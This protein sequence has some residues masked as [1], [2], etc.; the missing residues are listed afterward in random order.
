MKTSE[1]PHFNKKKKYLFRNYDH[2]IT[3][4]I[5][6]K[7][8]HDNFSKD[9]SN[10]INK[11]SLK[12]RLLTKQELKDHQLEINRILKSNLTPSGTKRKKVWD[13]GWKDILKGFKKNKKIQNLIPHYYKRG[14]TIMRFNK[15]YVLPEKRNFEAIF[16]KIVQRYIVEKYLKNY[17]H[18]Y[19]FGCG[20]GH[21]IL[22]FSKIL[23]SKKKFYGLDWS[24][25]S[26]KTINLIEKFKSNK[27]NHSFVSKN[28]DFFKVDKN[29]E[30][31]DD[32]VCLTWGSL[33]Q[34]GKNYKDVLDFF[35]RK[36]FKLI[37][38]IEP[39][40]E[41]YETKSRFDT[42]GLKY[43]NKR[44]YLYNYYKKIKF[45]EKTKKVKIIKYQRIVGSAFHDGWNIL[46]FKT[47]K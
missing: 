36:K 4:Q 43:H 19:E 33:E 46:V 8:F 47:L 10:Y 14:K 32:S 24:V 21:N 45:L 16:L 7:I 44:K 30:I 40:N 23:K 22:A 25:Y 3:S 39:F 41:I 1:S 5:L 12:Y 18:I 6:K 17:T 38:N 34:I 28:F 26:Q 11:L 37:I 35:L 29:Y 9:L 20:T 42:N 13:R 15:H 2:V 31:K 27:V